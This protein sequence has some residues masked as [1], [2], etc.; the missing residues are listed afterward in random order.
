MWP[1][2]NETRLQ[3]DKKELKAEFKIMITFS[4]TINFIAK[5]NRIYQKQ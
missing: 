1:V 3:V 4:E 2:F 5:R